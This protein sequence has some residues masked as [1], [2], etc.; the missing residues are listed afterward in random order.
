MG[1]QP[2]TSI[3]I[4]QVPFDSTYRH[5]RLFESRSEQQ[6]WFA[7]RC[8]QAL[9]RGDYTYQRTDHAVCVPFNAETLYGYNYCMYQNANYGSRWFYC[10]ITNIEYVNESTTRLY[11]R[12]DVMQTWFPELTVQACFVEREHV[13]D[14]SVGKHIKDEGLAPGELRLAGQLAYPFNLLEMTPV[15]S[16][17]VEPLADGTYVNV[18]G[19]RY[20]H[21]YSGTSLTAF[22]STNPLMEGQFKKFVQALADNGQQDAIS[23][24]YMVPSVM[25][26]SDQLHAKDNGYGM[27]IESTAAAP[28]EDF[29]V[30]LGF[31]TLD[32][33]TP[34]NNKTLV[35]PN[36]YLEVS[37]AS[38]ESS[39]FRLEFFPN[40][41]APVFEVAGGLLP[42]SRICAMPKDYNGASGSDVTLAVQ[43]PQFPTCSWVYQAFNNYLGQ[44]EGGNYG[45]MGWNSATEL[46]FYQ[47]MFGGGFS[48]ASGMLG[49]GS[50]GSA[51]L[52]GA[53]GVTGM[54]SELANANANLN[55]QSR[56]PN[57]L[58]GGL[59]TSTSLA[60]IRKYG[61]FYRRYTCRREI[62]EQID[63]FF[64]MYGYNVS[65]LK[66][67][68]L[69]GRRS[70]NFVK[71]SGANVRGKAPTAALDTINALLDSG[72]TF[73]HVDDV[74]DYSL[75]NSIV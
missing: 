53:S 67:P 41:S 5:V 10:F 43:L 6:A 48:T 52:A 32:G 27:W 72:T 20:Y 21:V 31:G 25:L 22:P 3:Y 46:P 57:T 74:G 29:T 7:S 42:E 38:G 16:S 1:F 65:V 11:L 23:A 75:D 70:W 66:K 54:L 12:T 63:D 26:T 58:R 24:I 61:V 51:A 62:A 35:F 33:Y 71:T 55:Y 45:V 69:T 56:Q 28:T 34:K 68:N 30:D 15:I 37:N 14:D 64:S 4:G 60:N 17:A 13:N 44:H 9:K 47:A 59:N 8:T 49:A 40:P 50:G 2:T 18:E 39:Q 73:W 19:D 36:Q